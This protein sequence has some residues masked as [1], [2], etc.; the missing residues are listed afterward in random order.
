MTAYH[1]QAAIAA[2]HAGGHATTPWAR[3]ALALRRSALAQPVAR[4]RAQPRRGAVEGLP[5]RPA[6]SR[7]S[8][9]SKGEPSLANYYLLP[10][11][12]GRLLA[13]MGDR[14]RAAAAFRE[15]LERA[16][17][18]ARAA[19]VD[20]APGGGGGNGDDGVNE[21]ARTRRNGV[22]KH[23]GNPSGRGPIVSV[24]LQCSAFDLGLLKSPF[25]PYLV[26]PCKNTFADLRRLR[27]LTPQYP[28][29]RDRPVIRPL[30]SRL[31]EAEVAC[32]A[33]DRTE[34]AAGR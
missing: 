12:K 30:R 22:T 7:R 20:A 19:V 31:R 32:G 3:G 10:A 23:G 24:G 13:E 25:T 26:P 18:R 17:Q 15:A 5:G 6:L 28:Q 8:P 27:Y 14:G 33:R 1:M 11:V 16:V 9:R 34:T 2:V 21:G 4:R 29:L